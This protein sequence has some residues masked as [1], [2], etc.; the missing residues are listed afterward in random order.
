MFL[1]SMIINRVISRN[2]HMV[3]FSCLFFL[4]VVP[5]ISIRWIW[6]FWQITCF[7]PYCPYQLSFPPKHHEPYCLRLNHN[8]LS[9]SL[10]TRFS[11][12]GIR[13]KI[14]ERRYGSID[15]VLSQ[16]FHQSSKNIAVWPILSSQGFFINFHKKLVLYLCFNYLLK[17]LNQGQYGLTHI[18]LSEKFDQLI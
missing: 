7:N 10:I 5:G 3:S 16:H 4:K 8:F 14:N 6:D 15:I 9:I 13:Q 2:Q 17:N 12:T 11:I 1:C 18:V